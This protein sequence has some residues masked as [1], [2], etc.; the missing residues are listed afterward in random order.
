MQVYKFGGASVKD[1]AGVKNLGAIV[2]HH[3]GETLLIVVSAMGK[4]TNALEEL[5]RFAFKGIN[6]E[7]PLNELVSYHSHICEELFGEVP[8]PVNHWIVSLRDSLKRTSAGTK[9][10]EYY[11]TVIP[12][13]ELLSTSIVHQYLAQ[14][15]NSTWLDARRYIKTN[16]R[17]TEANVEWQLTEHYISRDLPGL[18]K[19]GP[20][21]TQGFIGS[22]L[23]GKTTTLGREGS[24]YTGAIFAHCL[25]AESLTV[26]KDVP[27]LLNADPKKFPSA[28]LFEELSFQEVTEL[29]YYGA[30]VIHP[31]TIRPLA[32]R[33]I[34]LL[35]KSFLEPS[36]KGTRIH[37]HEKVGGK[38]CYVFK[39]NQL[40]VTLRVRDNSFMDE[41][42]L[43]KI[44]LAMDHVN[45][46]IN[47]MHSSALTFTFCMDYN[48]DKL[49][50]M[51]D[52][53]QHD[54]QILYNEGLELATI[55]NYTVDSLSMLPPLGE[56]ILEQK[57]RNNYQV[58][59]RP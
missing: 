22:D 43:G 53:L 9:W 47:M 5:A 14:K 39:E 50:A 51:K 11:D 25:K 48:E 7:D 52:Y 1:A 10:L 19:E 34:P 58:V 32:Q 35:V 54:F 26:W 56:V 37:E 20:V 42:K 24:D 45:I 27:G 57:T 31:K 13:G 44:F 38:P 6:Y 40:L 18:L 21:I 29:T 16:S 41:K 23:T 8:E 2:E 30:K 59:Y 3:K 36:G 49:E 28:E 15:F 33:N 17:F 55:K 4:T 46:K 12:Y